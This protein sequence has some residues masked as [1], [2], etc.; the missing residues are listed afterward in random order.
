MKDA[1]MYDLMMGTLNPNT[2]SYCE[3][4]LSNHKKNIIYLFR[5][6]LVENLKFRATW[7]LQ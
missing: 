3:L 1:D 6:S 7:V 2:V 5:P 4:Y